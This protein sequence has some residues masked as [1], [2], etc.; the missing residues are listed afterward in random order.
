MEARR[1]KDLNISPVRK[2]INSFKLPTTRCNASLRLLRDPLR[3][4]EMTCGRTTAKAHKNS[5]P[6]VSSDEGPRGK[7]IRTCV[8]KY[9][10]TSIAQLRAALALDSRCS[11]PITGVYTCV[12]NRLGSQEPY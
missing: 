9:V 5:A 7:N 11:F 1:G 12:A 6:I 8:C 3:R 10:A 4:L 2:F